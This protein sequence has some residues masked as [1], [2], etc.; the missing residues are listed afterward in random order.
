MENE[1]SLVVKYEGVIWLGVHVALTWISYAQYFLIILLDFIR[2]ATR[3]LK[4]G[5]SN[6]SK[7][8]EDAKL[9]SKVPKHIAI[10]V[11]AKSELEDLGNVIL[12]SIMLGIPYIT[13]HGQTELSH[14]STFEK[15][16]KICERKKL[17]FQENQI[18]INYHRDSRLI[19]GD[20]H[21]FNVMMSSIQY[22]RQRL[23]EVTRSLCQQVQQGMLSPNEID[24]NKMNESYGDLLPEPEFAISF[25]SYPC[26][27]G[28]DPWKTRLTEIIT[29]PSLSGISYPTYFS[30]LNKFANMRQRFGK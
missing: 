18:K 26:L 11:E 9:L 30:A 13:I 10:V 24:L 1:T 15:L 14:P 6:R 5:N 12:W 8:L 22:G 2:I 23:V 19:E 29:L 21:G 17:E 16:T 20:H 25:S 27:H 4:L 28:L 7:I 3:K